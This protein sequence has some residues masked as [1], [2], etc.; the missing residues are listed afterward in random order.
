LGEDVYEDEDNDVNESE[1]QLGKRLGDLMEMAWLH[2]KPKLEHDYSIT[3][4]ALSVMPEVYED[5]SRR[6]TGFHREAIE[7]V[8]RKQFPDQVIKNDPELQDMTQDEVVDLFWDEFKAFRNKTGPF[9]KQNRWNSASA[10]MGCSHIW[11]EKY[12]K[13]YTK[14]VGKVGCKST[15][16][17][18][19]IGPCE[20]NWGGVKGIKSGNRALI[21]GKAT[22][23]R[24]IVYTSA[25]Q[26]EARA[27]RKTEESLQEKT[28]NVIFGDDDMKCVHLFVDIYIHS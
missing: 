8:V 5:C 7:R 22:A 1:D 11:H 14:V 3:A 15:S 12:S 17:N 23:K 6:L 13:P 28:G 9:E 25:M 16:P 26:S 18:P 21:S 10:R 20:R 4:W 2:R 24:A 27:R 19:G